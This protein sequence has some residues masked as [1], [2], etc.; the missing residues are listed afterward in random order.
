MPKLKIGKYTETDSMSNLIGKNYPALLVLS[1][2]GIKLGFRDKSIEEVC[3]DNSVDT[4]T[5]L[6]IVNLLLHNDTKPDYADYDSFLLSLIA[7]LHNSHDYFVNY[8]LPDIREKLKNALQQDSKDLNK[9]V[10]YYFDEY[11]SEVRKH[12]SYEEKT[13]FPYV[14]SLLAGNGKGKYNI[15]IFSKQHN[16]VEAKLSEFK[17][18]M[19]KYYDTESTNEI[20][21]VLCDIFNC[22]NDLALHNAVEDKLF[23]PAILELEIK[24]SVNTL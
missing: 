19:I 1:R 15:G 21:N 12:M 6:A 10:L 24:K 16:Q 7:Y 23:V 14:R 2:F 13:V 22:E 4:K 8:R 20:N 17:N 5:F 11:V 9:A 3:N 18:I